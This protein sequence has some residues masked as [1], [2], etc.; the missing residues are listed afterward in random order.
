MS[1]DI[2]YVDYTRLFLDKQNPRLPEG[3]S[4]DEKSML[5]HIALTTSIE[6]LMGAI[7]ENGFFPGEPL[8]TIQ[9]GDKYIVVEGNRRLTAIKLIHDP[10]IIERPSSKIIRL[11]EGANNKG[12][13]LEIPVIVRESREEVLP[14]LGFRHI[15][16]VKQ[17][18]PLAKARY[19]EQLFHNTDSNLSPSDRYLDV[20][21]TIGSR[22]DHIERNLDALAAY[23]V[24]EKN[25]FYD[26]NGLDEESIK[27]A[28]LSTALADERIGLFAG[29]STKDDN[30]FIFSNDVIENQSLLDNQ[31]L[32]DLTLWLFNKD[33][34]G[35][36]RVGESRNLRLLSAVVDNQKALQ[37]FR[38]GSELK[39]AYQHT[40]GVQEDFIQMLYQAESL[41]MDA[42]G[43]VANVD[44]DQEGLDT[45][46]RIGKN[47]K[48]IW[49]T[50]KSKKESEDDEF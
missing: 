33:K 14:Y 2:K 11:S 48:H 5:T 13:F 49:E 26:I 32:K 12:D 44:Y 24:I 42:A 45:A 50:I 9:E 38:N 43:M 29:I 34:D 6:D 28:V 37:M 22:K 27:F 8:I 21:R 31:N 10:W 35:R 40:Q 18:E 25:K 46:R 3:V 19:M 7:V 36:T 20:A 30:G 16:G 41:I 39:S 47:I 1:G 17:W 23:R 4:R 15:T